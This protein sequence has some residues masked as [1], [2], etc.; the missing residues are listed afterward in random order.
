MVVALDAVGRLLDREQD[1]RPMIEMTETVKA[2]TSPVRLVSETPLS[3][4]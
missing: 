2:V 3:G 1:H 4:P